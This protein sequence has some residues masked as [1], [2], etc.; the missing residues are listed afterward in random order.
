VKLFP[1]FLQASTSCYKIRYRNSQE[2]D[3]L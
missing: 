3:C 2:I 1:Y